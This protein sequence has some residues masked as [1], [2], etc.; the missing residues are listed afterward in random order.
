MNNKT[1][2]F[3]FGSIILIILVA[4]III[5]IYPNYQIYKLDCYNQPNDVYLGTQILNVTGHDYT[6]GTSSCYIQNINKM[7]NGFVNKT[8]CVFTGHHGIS[9]CDIYQEGDIEVC[10]R[11]EKIDNFIVNI[12][13]DWLISN[14]ITKTACEGSPTA[15]ADC[16]AHNQKDIK[17]ECNIN[18]T[19]Y[20]VTK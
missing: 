18:G 5:S 20:E 9:K 10:N 13:K 3:L 11:T 8:V 12:N 19:R 14:C 17:W 4:M 6:T 1:R 7:F 16:I 15:Q 2:F